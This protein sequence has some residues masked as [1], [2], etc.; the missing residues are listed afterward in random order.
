M[1]STDIWDPADEP[2]HWVSAAGCIAAV[3]ATQGRRLGLG[4]GGL[5]MWL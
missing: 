5:R 2:W 3:T 1:G 4:P